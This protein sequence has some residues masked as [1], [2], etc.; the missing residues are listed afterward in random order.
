M[1]NLTEEISYFG[2]LNKNFKEATNPEGIKKLPFL[3]Q[4]IPIII[5]NWNGMN[6]TIECVN[7]VLNSSYTNYKI[8]LIDNYSSDNS[9]KSFEKLYQNNPKINIVFNTANLGF[10]LATNRILVKLLKV[11]SPPPYVALLNNDTIVESDWLYNLLL[12]AKTE[13]AAI[14]SSKMIDYYDHA[15]MDNAG[16]YM[17]NTGEILPIGHGQHPS[18]FDQEFENWGACA[19]ACL[20]SSKMLQKI[21]WF[22]EY[23]QT[24]YEDAE[25]GV[26][27]RLTGHNVFMS[28]RP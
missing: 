13:D 26:R 16:H 11:D 20:Y 19:G 1:K 14:V 3:N 6:D 24:G 23:F 4:E 8:Y 10:T 22:D 12:K 5:I 15:R 2:N 25:F 28:Q 18:K 9:F 7:S 21:G 27:A 17:L